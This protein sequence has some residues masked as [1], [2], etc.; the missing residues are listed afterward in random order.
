MRI[1]LLGICGTFMG[2]LAVLAKQMGVTVSGSDQNIYPPM[3]TQLINQGIQLMEGYDAIELDKSIETVVVGNVIRRGNPLM[4]S[5]MA[6]QLPWVSGPAW[7]YDTILKD[8]HVLAVSGT[9]GKT[10][11]TSMLAWILE[12]AGLNPS[13]LVGGVPENFAVS[14]RLTDSPFFV[15]E[16]DEYDSAFFDKRSKFLHYRPRTLILNNL[17]FDHADI[18]SDLSVIQQQFHQLIRT[19]PNNGRIIYPAADEALVEVLEMGCWTPRVTFGDRHGQWRAKLLKEDGTHFAVCREAPIGEVQWDLLG[20][21]NVNNALAAIAAAKH[22]GVAPEVAIAALAQF[23]GVR[24]RMELKGD[25]NGIKIYDDFAH[26]PTAIATTLAGLRATL[27]VSARILAVLE[28]GSYTM[29]SGYHKESLAA[30]LVDA[31]WVGCCHPNVE[32]DVADAFAKCEQPVELV[33]QADDLLGKI[34]SIASPGDH[35]I[36]MS[37]SG[38]GQLQQ[39]VLRHLQQTAEVSVC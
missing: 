29:R 12:F 24:R 38:F 9:H 36:F 37:N 1:H 11:T 30:S 39:K 23:K 3:S 32:W 33:T 15:V 25:I 26:H 14:A 21:H 10:T 4:E 31:D 6:S 5:I 35:I 7:L 19:V 16:A 13:F 20:K 28:L 8:R 27:P 17:E 22:V 18:F 34:I 2:G